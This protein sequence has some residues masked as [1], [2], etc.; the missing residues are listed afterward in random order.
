MNHGVHKEKAEAVR[1]R[2]FHSV[3]GHAS[4]EFATSPRVLMFI[5]QGVS[6]GV[7]PSSSY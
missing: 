3:S 6:L 5:R 4:S 7:L 1:Q 2:Q